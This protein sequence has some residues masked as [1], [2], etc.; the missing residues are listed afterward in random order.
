MCVGGGRWTLCL[1]SQILPPRAVHYQTNSATRRDHC[2][3]FR[4]YCRLQ[5]TR[6]QPWINLGTLLALSSEQGKKTKTK[7]TCHKPS[8]RFSGVTE[9]V[10]Q[11]YSPSLPSWVVTCTQPSLYEF[12]LCWLTPFSSCLLTPT[13]RFLVTSLTDSDSNTCSSASSKRKVQTSA[14]SH[15][16]EGFLGKV[17]RSVTCLRLSHL[18]H[19]PQFLADTPHHPANFKLTHKQNCWYIQVAMDI[20]VSDFPA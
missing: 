16:A 13:M 5:A 8:Q 15:Q 4:Q 10:F 3:T 20:V 14:F 9:A 12:M 2:G 6:V 7:T 17:G 18:L 19:L 11:T 1:S